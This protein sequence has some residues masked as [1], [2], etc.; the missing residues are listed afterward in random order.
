MALLLILWT[1]IPLLL[2]LL[3]TRNPFGFINKTKRHDH[4]YHGVKIGEHGNITDQILKHIFINNLENKISVA[5]LTIQNYTVLPDK[6]EDFKNTFITGNNIVKNMGMFKEELWDFLKYFRSAQESLM[7]SYTKGKNLHIIKV[8]MS[9]FQFK[10]YEEARVIERKVEL[11]N[12]KRKRRNVG[13]EGDVFDDS[14]ST[15]RIFSRAFCNFVFP[16]E[17]KRPMPSTT[18]DIEDAIQ[19]LD[20]NII[21][22]VPIE[23]KITGKYYF[24]N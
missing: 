11:Q 6:L 4:E 20:E 10:V 18:N 8:D 24:R 14:V 23:Q 1:I 7:P 22:A 5:N 9:E 19:N 3:I 12:S 17:H 21:D 16:T 13:K 2:L 15:Y